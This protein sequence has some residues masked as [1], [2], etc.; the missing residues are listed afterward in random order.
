MVLTYEL[1]F[2]GSVTEVSLRAL[3]GLGWAPFAV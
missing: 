1:R 3:G 2:G